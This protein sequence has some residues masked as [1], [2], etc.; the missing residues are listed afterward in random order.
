MLID[1]GNN[2]SLE[3]Q[4]SMWEREIKKIKS[5]IQMKER[6]LENLKQTLKKIK[7]RGP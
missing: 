5:E 4:A 6:K 1:K 7:R 3:L 2:R